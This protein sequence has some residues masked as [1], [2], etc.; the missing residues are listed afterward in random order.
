MSSLSERLL[1]GCHGNLGADVD[2]L[3]GLTLNH[4]NDGSSE[5]AGRHHLEFLTL[6]LNHAG[7]TGTTHFLL[8]IT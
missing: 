5:P 4:P 8:A 7:K 2:P 3:P 1:G 6:S